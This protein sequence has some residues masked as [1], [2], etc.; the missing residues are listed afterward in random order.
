MSVAEWNGLGTTSYGKGKKRANRPAI[1]MRIGMNNNS[2]RK[3]K[4]QR[5]EKFSQHGLVEIVGKER[6]KQTGVD[7]TNGG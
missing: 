7:Q 6:S 2:A 5:K 4:K 3:N 1:H